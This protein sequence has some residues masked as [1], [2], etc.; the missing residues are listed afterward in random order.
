MAT[1]LYLRGNSSSFGIRSLSK[2]GKKQ[3]RSIYSK[4]YPGSAVIGQCEWCK[5][6]IIRAD[7]FV[8]EEHNA[9]LSNKFIHH[10]PRHDCLLKY[11]DDKKKKEQEKE[12]AKEEE[13]KKKQEPPNALD[14][15]W[16][17]L[18]V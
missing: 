2:F 5:Q 10:S 1:V 14:E 15:F 17:H 13:Q 16:K 4:K 18:G 9:G 11:W 8:V 3:P 12:K 7:P 6:D